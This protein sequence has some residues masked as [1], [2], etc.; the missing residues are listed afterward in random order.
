MVSFQSSTTFNVQLLQC[1]GIWGACVCINLL[2][3]LNSLVPEA[4]H[5]HQHSSLPSCNAGLFPVTAPTQHQEFKTVKCWRW[6]QM[7]G[8]IPNLVYSF[9]DKTVAKLKFKFCQFSIKWNSC[10]I[11]FIFWEC[12]LL[13]LIQNKFCVKK[14]KKK[15]LRWLSM[16]ITIRWYPALIMIFYRRYYIHL[17]TLLPPFCSSTVAAKEEGLWGLQS[18]AG[19]TVCIFA[20]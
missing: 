17:H 15:F 19:D 12:L 20:R 11:I 5:C 7:F 2:L 18:I 8:E 1:F 4:T 14:K 16:C 10:G 13:C 6:H 3:K 9:N